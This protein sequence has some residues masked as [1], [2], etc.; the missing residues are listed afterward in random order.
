VNGKAKASAV[1]ALV[2]DQLALLQ[3]EVRAIRGSLV[4]T[5]DGLLVA[6]NLP[7]D[8]PEQLAALTSTL[9]G[10]A[11]YAI[12]VT[13]TGTLI[14]AVARGTGGYLAAYALGEV[15]ALAVVGDADL[16]VAM[17]H[18]KTR[19]VVERLVALS[20]RFVGFVDAAGAVEGAAMEGWP[21][22][23]PRRYRSR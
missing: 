1:E 10:L 22:P 21:R 20:D 23:H 7:D 19:P 9:V 4:A 2:A 5:S 15:A 11:D 17:L 13:R 3:Q 16:N 14:E 18:H 8:Q 6:S 12:E